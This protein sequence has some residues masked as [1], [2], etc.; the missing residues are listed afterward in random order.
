MASVEDLEIMVRRLTTVLSKVSPNHPMIRKAR[1]ALCSTDEVFVRVDNFDGVKLKKTALTG[2]ILFKQIDQ[3]GEVYADQNNCWTPNITEARV[4]T[5][6][7]EPWVEP[8][9]SDVYDW[10]DSTDYIDFK[11]LTDHEVFARAFLELRLLPAHKTTI[12]D[13]ITDKMII[14]GEVDGNRYRIT[15][16]STMGDV[17]IHSNIKETCGYVKRV[18]ISDISNWNCYWQESTHVVE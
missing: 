3:I 15:G 18:L 9:L 2:F 8:N 1:S 7:P 6:P 14:T 4:F 10:L 11:T 13:A 17:F 16:A 12:Y 5:T